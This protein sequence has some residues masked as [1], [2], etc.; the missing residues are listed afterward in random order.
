ML[1]LELM[2]LISAVF[3]LGKSASAAADSAG[4]LAGYLKISQLAIGLFL[5][6]AMTSLPELAIS[7]T[8]ALAGQGT[9]SA[10]NVIGANIA[11]VLLVMGASAALFGFAVSRETLGNLRPV[12]SAT[13][14]ISLALLAYSLLGRPLGFIEGIALVSIGAAYSLWAIY[15]N[16][17]EGGKPE[18][19]S[20][21]EA[22]P[23]LFIFVIAIG[24][25]LVC[26]NL[27]VFSA[28]RLADEAGLSKSFIGASI[29]SI[30]T[31][32]PELSV[33]LAAAR[34][35]NFGLSIGNAI[36]SIM[37]NI[38]LVL[39]AGAILSP[40]PLGSGVIAA[41]LI[42][43][44]AANLLFYR[45]AETREKFGSAQG[46]SLLALYAFYLAAIYFMQGF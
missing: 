31:T 38:T 41:A 12:F 21:Q 6:A 28:V 39:G 34:R 22:I 45:V 37:V 9:I 5:V 33:S 3:V 46:I 10:G 2:L 26:A 18:K 30:G 19:A 13:I 23:S 8:S 27:V 20:K 43:S 25:V 29:I 16:D 32:L 24:A 11:D 40:V 35:K 4:R 15:R 7:I 36:G 42:F 14:I 1:A 17:G 44:M